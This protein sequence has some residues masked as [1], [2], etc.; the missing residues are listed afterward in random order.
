MANSKADTH[1]NNDAETDF[2]GRVRLN[3]QELIFDARFSRH[4]RTLH[5]IACR[6][7]GGPERAEEAIG[8]CWRIASRH[9]QRFEHEGEFNSWLLRIVIDEALVL[10][11]E[12][13][14][15]PTPK[16]LCEPVAARVFRSNDVSD[17]KGD[18]RTDDQ[19]RFPQ[20]F[21]TALE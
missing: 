4:Y 14:P 20:D 5:F 1:F 19:D 8:R 12:S 15:M 6:V 10:L 3:Q 2:A 13:V 17:S 7:L 11:R 18:T 21:S 16:V 9:P